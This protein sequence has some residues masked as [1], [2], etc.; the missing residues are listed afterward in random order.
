[1]SEIDLFSDNIRRK[2]EI[3]SW[4]NAAPILAYS[5][6]DQFK[7][8]VDALEKFQ[9][10][11]EMIRRPGG[12][13]SEIADYVDTLFPAPE[14]VETRISAD[15]LVKLAEAKSGEILQYVRKGFLDG[16]RIDFV[17]G[18]V[19]LDLEWNSKDQTFDRDLYA[20][21]A[22]YG[23]GAIDV[24]IVLTRGAS[25]DNA[26]FQSLGKGSEQGWNRRHRRRV[27]E[28]WGIDHLDGK[29]SLQA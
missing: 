24:G 3:Y 14:W 12:R 20:F 11:T 19:A 2:F 5:F 23:V 26:F 7:H 10:T 1:M 21:S 29:T 16:H 4:R 18:K 8:V 9:I 15:L 17:S 25:L 13:K 6:P 22:F 28:I 27:Q